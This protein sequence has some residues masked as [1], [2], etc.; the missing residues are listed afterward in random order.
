MKFYQLEH[1]PDGQ[2]RHVQPSRPKRSR[3]WKYALFAT[4]LGL[5]AFT[6]WPIVFSTPE[7]PCVGSARYCE[8]MARPNPSRVWL[9]RWRGGWGGGCTPWKVVTN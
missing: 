8:A 3:R 7:E 9:E 4:V 1:G 5:V 2:L 6:A